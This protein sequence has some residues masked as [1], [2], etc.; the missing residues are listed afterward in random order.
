MAKQARNT[1]IEVVAP[2]ADGA[3]HYALSARAALLAV[4]GLEGKVQQTLQGVKTEAKFKG[5]N[6]RA[7]ALAAIL[8]GVPNAD[9]FTFEQAVA[10]L[11]A[12]KDRIRLGSGTPRSYCKAFVANGY[13]A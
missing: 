1:E 6:T 8:H 13:F 11:T 10:A 3:K 9:A 4:S 5:D 7:H 12:A 2:V